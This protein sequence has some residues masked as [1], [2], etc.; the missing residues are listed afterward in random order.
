MIPVALAVSVLMSWIV[1]LI[2]LGPVS[3]CWCI[4]IHRL[5]GDGGRQTQLFPLIA[6]ME[7]DYIFDDR[8]D[9]EISPA[10]IL[11]WLRQ[12]SSAPR[13][14]IKLWEDY[15][16]MCSFQRTLRYVYR[17][18]NFASYYPAVG[19]PRSIGLDMD[20]AQNV[21]LSPLRTCG[22]GYTSTTWIDQ[23]RKITPI[24]VDKFIRGN[25][26]T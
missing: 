20:P 18:T 15:A 16:H 25:L 24:P 1:G 22:E 13:D 9:F 5:G 12:T 17:T 26:G 4:P 19:P 14:L 8:E 21:Y 10:P 2:W 3:D 23:W 11:S 7:P 6:S